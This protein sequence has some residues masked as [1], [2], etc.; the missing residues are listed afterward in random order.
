MSSIDIQQ[1][2]ILVVD[3]DRVM[4]T[5]FVGVLRRE[6]FHAVDIA[7]SGNE[8]LEKLKEQNPDVVFLDIEMPD[9]SGLE[10]LKAIKEQGAETKVVMVTAT[11]SAHNV[12][13]AKESGADGFLVKPVSPKKVADAIKACG[14]KLA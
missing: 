3:D 9:L 13:A 11:P 1:L 7:K 6:G 14:F 10:A 5:L 4:L 12:M 8:A 2:R